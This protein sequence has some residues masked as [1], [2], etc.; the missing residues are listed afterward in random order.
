MSLR[1]PSSF[2]L[3]GLPQVLALRRIEPALSSHPPHTK[4][5]SDKDTFT[6][7]LEP[8]LSVAFR[9]AYNLTRNTHDAEELVQEA[10]ILAYR[11]FDSFRRGTNFK[12]WFLKII[13]NCFLMT[14]RK[15]QRQPE[16]LEMSDEPAT[17][18]FDRA[19]TSEFFATSHDPAADLLQEI[20]A[21]QLADALNQ[22]PEDYR[23]VA[24]F[25]FVEELS[26]QDIAE[27][28]AI[29]IGTVRSRLHRSRR[30]LQKL[31][32]SLA[33]ESNLFK[34]ATFEGPP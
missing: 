13:K 9:V 4:H 25:Y 27:Y 17:Y 11:K 14:V 26:Y 23:L 8:V 20:S 3:S 19:V 24:V 31:L 16:T 2:A 6:A 1:H 10:C 32:W 21:Q 22:L 12:A 30:I 15:Q 5:L 29:P 34:T 18:M 28:L 7:L 33:S